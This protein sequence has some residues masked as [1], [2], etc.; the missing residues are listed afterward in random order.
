[1]E[2]DIIMDGVDVEKIL[3]SMT[4]EEKVS[5]LV[6]DSPAIKRLGIKKY[7]WWNECL[8]GVARAGLATVFPQTIGIAATWN[9]NLVLDIANAISN[10]ARAK[11]HEFD[12]QGKNEIY[13]G[14]TYWSPNINIFR[15]PRWGRGMETYGE[16]P[17]LTSA[18]AVPFIKGLQGDHPKYL[19]LIATP[20][21]FAVH[22]GP[23]DSRHTFNATPS[24]IDLW[25]TYLPA[26]EACI[27]EGG[28]YSIMGAYNRLYGEACTAS[29][30]LL[31]TI[32]REKWKFE[33]YTVSDAGAITDIAEHH[34]I[35]TSLAEAAALALKSGTD[36]CAGTE[37]LHLVEA[38]EK[39]FITE[40]ELNISVSRLLKAKKKLGLL[41]NENGN[42][43][44]KIP[45]DIVN[46]KHHQDLALQVARE[47]IVLLKNEDALLPLSKKLNKIAVIGPNAN[48]T[49]I[50]LGNYHGT[51][52]SLV[53]LY[54]GIKNK[55]G[56]T[57]EVVYEQGCEL[58]EGLPTMKVLTQADTYT[59]DTKGFSVKYFNNSKFSGT[60]IQ[61]LF[62]PEFDLKLFDNLD[63][64]VTDTD[65]FGIIVSCLFIP[66]ESGQY[67]FGVQGL[68]AFELFI[69]DCLLT[70][71]NTI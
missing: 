63:A 35:T 20:K 16:D 26:F 5:Q 8:H 52:Y 70:S 32:L 51:P 50:H 68:T 10:E 6:H 23:E 12:R 66:Q 15:D 30:F 34:K 39:G 21:H 14:L 38:I 53:S 41:A 54:Q 33:G 29:D 27:K 18:L 56:A 28:A 40:E 17:Y 45:F 9:D 19:K 42:P 11:H 67:A 46:C 37:Y 43:Y 71:F 24:N 31:K 62:I 2:K 64:I 36:L 57:C 48:E 55:L 44:S 25:E 13:Q 22:S 1:M 69:N 61:E 60:P 49:D 58:A 59:D 65:N 47:S 3:N 7:N 4:L